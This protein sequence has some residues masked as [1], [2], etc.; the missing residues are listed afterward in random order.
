MLSSANNIYESITNGVKNRKKKLA[1]LIDPDKFKSTT[2]L[3]NGIE[4][5]LDFIFVGGSIL[6]KGS[7][8]RCVEIIKKSTDIPLVLFPGSPDQIDPY[9]DGILFLSLISGR[10]PDNLIGKHVTS[11]PILKKTSLEIIPTG[12]MLIDGG[13]ATSASYMSNTLP[14]PYNKSDIAV[15]TAMAGEML[16]L[17]L[18]YLDTGSGSLKHVSAKM[19][20]EV[21]KNINI[22]LI[23]GGGIKTPE[24][25]YDLCTA[26][27]DMLVI[28][29]IAE[30]SPE[31][32]SDLVSA[33]NQSSKYIAAAKD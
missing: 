27:A 23:V 5:G 19:V 9:A 22:P 6:T 3:K 28:G 33:V 8:Q 26:G 10:N 31:L 2:A 11:A 16:G 1:L 30:Q 18:I 12:Y 15:C 14:I 17:K 21:K 25:A 24:N 4:A 32:I 20:S 29:T 13:N 7:L